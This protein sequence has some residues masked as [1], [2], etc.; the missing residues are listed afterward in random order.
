[1]T[2][3]SDKL[4]P[5]TLTLGETGTPTEFGSQI[6]K[7]TL[8]PK[9]DEADPIPVLSGEE[10]PGASTESYTLS[11][12]FLQDYSGME[13]LIV[14]CKENSGAALPYVFTPLTA[15]G[16]KVSGTVVVRAVPFGG[17]VKARNTSAFEWTGVGD[18]T[19]AA[20]A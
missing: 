11:G 18:Y 16:L 2:V 20:T 4:G 7:C 1:M 3:K 9:V 14:W 13:S 8:T 6:T 5:G 19:Y 10:V 17:D 15:G 12:E